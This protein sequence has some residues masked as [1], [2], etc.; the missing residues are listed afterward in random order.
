MDFSDHK[1]RVLTALLC[2]IAV[3]LSINTTGAAL[4]ETVRR[5]SA[6]ATQGRQG[7]M[8][9]LL[10]RMDEFTTVTEPLETTKTP[11]KPVKSKKATI[12]SESAQSIKPI[13]SAQPA[14]PVKAVEKSAESTKA[15]A[16]SIKTSKPTE[17]L[18]PVEP[19][20]KEEPARAVEKQADSK[21]VN[22]DFTDVPLSE[23]LA[24]IAQ[25]TD[26]NIIG[27]EEVSQKISVHLKDVPLDILFDIIL[28]STDYG[29]VEEGKIIRIVPKVDL[30]VGT[31]VFELQHASAEKVIEAA[32]HLL[33]HN[34]KIKSFSNFSQNVPTNILVV[35]DVSESMREIKALIEKLDKK[36]KQVMIEVKFCEVTLDEDDEL[37]IDWAI[38]ATL[39]GGKSYTTFPF[40]RA[41]ERA[42]EPVAPVDRNTKIQFEDDTVGEAGTVDFSTFKARL[43]A[44]NS[45]TRIKLIASPQVAARSGQTAQI[46]IGDKIPIP[47]YERSA[48]TGSMEVTGYAEENVGILLEV[49]PFVN[50]D[51]SVTLNVHPEVSEIGGA[52]GPNGERPIVSTRE[53]TTVFTVAD[54]E[55]IVLG[56]LKR[57]KVT[58][59]ENKVPFLGSIPF[60]GRL[61]F[62]YKDDKDERRELLLFITPHVLGDRKKETAEGSS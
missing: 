35:T 61:L 49:T 27:G 32:A 43:H 17:S 13:S 36:V 26:L 4:N 7:V 1:W 50:N 18:K 52:T 37:G 55:T 2:F 47:L 9:Q 54:G 10:Q 38:D 58:T 42:L 28:K 40:G 25:N 21:K 3:G 11:S 29:Y 56:G 48:E 39:S 57:Q 30:P 24:T 5:E 19:V 53:I 12:Q 62:T 41:Y 34:G 60:L 31:E 45:K 14:A 23:I 51:S 44:L 6:E 15:V 20:K 33:T 16:E 46:I 22:I 59:T 8:E